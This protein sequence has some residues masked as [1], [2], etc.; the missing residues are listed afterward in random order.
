MLTRYAFPE[1]RYAITVLGFDAS[2]TYARRNS[3]LGVVN[4]LHRCVCL[5]Y[6]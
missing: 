3:R 2:E 4:V 6:H 5:S 1:R